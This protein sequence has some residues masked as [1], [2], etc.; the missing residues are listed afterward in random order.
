M[1]DFASL[2]LDMC[3]AYDRIE[4]CFLDQM[5]LG[6][7]FHA[8]CVSKVMLWIKSV[9]YQ[10][11]FNGRS[12]DLITPG[13][14]LRT[15]VLFVRSGCQLELSRAKGI[16]PSDLASIFRGWFHPLFQGYWELHSWSE[17]KYKWR[18]NANGLFTNKSAYDLLSSGGTSVDR[19]KGFPLASADPLGKLSFS[20]RDACG[21]LR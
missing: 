6:P 18:P 11:T 4:W 9:E 8:E 19:A 15:F 10:I 13:R 3:K 16:C 5:L 17:E 14:G 12:T 7:G 20:W 2:K 21:D 1:H